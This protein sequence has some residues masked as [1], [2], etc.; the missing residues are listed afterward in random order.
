MLDQNVFRPDKGRPLRI[1]IKSPQGGRVTVRV[2]NVAG[3]K[4]RAPFE[5]DVP[6][7]LTVEAVWDGRN[8]AGEL[9]G[10]GVYIISV[11]G[12]GISRSLKLVLLK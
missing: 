5:A 2:F 1:G 11:K 6:K 10:S 8:E 3:E 12:A 7:D 9:C 4:V